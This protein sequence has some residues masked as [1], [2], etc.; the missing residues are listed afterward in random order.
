MNS[1]TP[2]PP[3]ISQSRITFH[4]TVVV[5]GK[6]GLGKRVRAVL[7]D[8]GP[9]GEVWV[10]IR[11]MFEGVAGFAMRWEQEKKELN[12]WHIPA[13]GPASLFSDLRLPSGFSAPAYEHFTK[14]TP[15]E[16]YA[17]AFENAEAAYRVN[18]YFLAAVAVLESDFGRSRIAK[19]KNNLFGWG[20]F[21]ED[22]YGKAW[23]FKT[24]EEGVNTVAAYLARDYLHP[25]GT[26]FS[27]K[28]GPCLKGVG[29]RY[30]TDENWAKKVL[31]I[32][33]RMAKLGGLP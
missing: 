27:K 31:A 22:P 21:D 14:G 29:E 16:K 19:E 8:W 23:A 11:E 26:Y 28:Y 25:N 13:A 24:V 20:A 5:W 7:I 17:L 6:H 9:A 32:W 4:P 10:P 12:I 33:D 18:G 1:L 2:L 3:E 15:M 30:A